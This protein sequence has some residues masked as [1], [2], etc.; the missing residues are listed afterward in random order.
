RDVEQVLDQ[1]R[2]GLGGALDGLA[3]APDLRGGQVGVAQELRVHHYGRERRAQ[4]VREGGEEG[5]LGAVGLLGRVARLL[6]LLQQP[7]AGADILDREEDHRLRIAEVDRARRERHRRP[8]DA[9]ELALDLE[10]LER[11]AF[12][13]Q[14]LETVTERR[15]VPGA[16]R[17]SEE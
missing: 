11:L 12:L 6:R 2:L 9:R 1:L 15:D 5:V 17:E 7:L 4:L 16:L 14:G 8:S 3:G 10:A 13:E